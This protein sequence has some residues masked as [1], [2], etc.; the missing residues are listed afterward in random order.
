MKT[1]L[2]ILVATVSTTLAAEQP[3]LRCVIEPE[4]VAE[5]GSPV[6]GVIE[7]I[8]IERGDFVQKGQILAQLSATVERATLG[9]AKSRAAS[10]ADVQ[11]AAA[12]D[13]LQRL[14][15]ART[16]E[17]IQK[18]FVALQVLE[19][20]RAE[21]SVAEQKLAQAREQRHIAQQELGLA[22]AQLDLRSIRAPFGGIVAERYVN[23]GERVELHPLFRLAKIDS[24]KVEII[25]PA[26]LFGAV[27]T[28][29][30]ARITPDLP[31]AA[32][33]EARI[34]LVDG[35]VDAASNTFRVR[36]EIPRGDH[37]VASGLRCVAELPGLPV[38]QA[39]M[40]AGALSPN[41]PN[42][43]RSLAGLNAFPPRAH[44]RDR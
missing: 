8:F 7:T 35:L 2:T 19:Q 29:M 9:A 32:D 26:S 42:L 25:A 20:V 18:K 36:A 34:I 6:I 40:P 30:A 13:E 38:A 15:L 22:Q 39:A 37:A 41:D 24:L 23:T 14:K 43:Q 12:N 31:N 21:T 28:G 4:K 1:L 16:E 11:A 33:I 10:Q 27:T 3:P 17:L 44:T 5:I